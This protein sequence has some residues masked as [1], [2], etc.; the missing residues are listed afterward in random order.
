[1]ARIRT[2]K[3]EF[4]TNELLSALPESTHM[5]AGALLNYADDYGYFNAN[6]ALV[7]ATCFP[8]REPLVSIP[9]S[10]MKLSQIGY[11][12][13]RTAEDG[14]V[15]GR[16]VNFD[17]HQKVGHPTASKI[18]PIFGRIE[19]KT[20][21]SHESPVNPHEKF[22]QSPETFTPEQ[23]TGNREQGRE[24][25]ETRKRA[26]SLAEWTEYAVSQGMGKQDAENAWHHYESQSWMRGKTPITKWRSCVATCL[27]RS[28]SPTN[29]KSQTALERR[30][31]ILGLQP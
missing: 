1:M 18:A 13:L 2:I 7:K 12:E 6:P 21:A 10:L 20:P 22:M 16:I 19:S 4:W 3:P 17:E 26:P 9:E 29:G 24:E 14:R 27:S 28:R 30:N 5:L 8:I 25:R 15:Y 23:G 11:I 31:Q